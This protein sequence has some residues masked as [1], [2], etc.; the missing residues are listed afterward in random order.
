[1]SICLFYPLTPKRQIKKSRKRQQRYSALCDSVVSI[2]QKVY[3]YDTSP[4]L[5]GIV[6]A[7]LERKKVEKK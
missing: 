5:V 2:I 1:M 3:L 7:V 4:F 6:L